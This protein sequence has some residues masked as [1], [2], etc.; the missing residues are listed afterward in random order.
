MHPG[1]HAQTQPDRI[2]IVRPS[3]GESL[4]YRELD[5]RANRVA[6]LLYDAGLRRGDHVALY[7]E[8][9]LAYFEVIWACMRSGLYFT[10]INFHLT[11]PEAAY[12]VDDC[13]AKALVASAGL[14]Q[15]P[16]LGRLTPRCEVKLS[17]GGEAEGFRP[18]EAALAG[19]AETP[20]ADQWLGA[21]M[22]Y[23]SGTTGRPKGIKRPLPDGKPDSGSPHTQVLIAMF[24]LDSDVVYLST[25]PMYHAAPI[26]YTSAVVQRGGTVVMMDRFEPETALRLIEEHKVTHSQW[27]PTMFIRMLRLD[28]EI[29]SKY[30]LSSHRCAIHAAAPCPVE[31]KKRMIEWW[32]PIVEE[33]YS[34]TEGAGISRISSRE[35]LDHPGSVGRSMGTPFHICDEE[36]KELP[37]GE[38]GLIYGEAPGGVGFVYHKDEEKTAGATHPLH[39]DWRTVGDV[40]Y[41]DEEGYLYL[42]DRKAFVINSG[43]VNIYPQQI[44]D[45]LALHPRVADVAVIGVPNADLGEEVKAVVQPAADARPGEALAQEILAFITERLGRQLTPRSVDFVDELPRLPTGKLA[46]KELRA[47]YWD[48]RPETA[49]LSSRI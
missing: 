36:G 31:V 42:T 49:S 45:A 1:I 33:Y 38:P 5:A 37:P 10:P 23:S 11:A 15:V 9:H 3:T 8:N 48:N 25:A 7:L 28:P 47:R 21:M 18:Y 44:E 6:N 13:D 2:A 39:P 14:D 22:L 20:I 40:G 27:V 43:G 4:T 30:D 19:S 46:K 41:L 34:S 17:V 12:I 24:S 16:E 29:R 32:G 35:W 26:G